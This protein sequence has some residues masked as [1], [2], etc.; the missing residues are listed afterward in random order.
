MKSVYDMTIAA[1]SLAGALAAIG[2]GYTT[3]T[4]NMPFE[5]KETHADDMRL[6]NVQIAQAKVDTA[7]TR[8]LIQSMQRDQWRSLQL[9]LQQRIDAL[10][11][12]INNPQ[13]SPPVRGQLLQARAE[14][15]QQLNEVSVRLNR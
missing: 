2:I 8:M 4:D 7:D 13:T 14:A 10:A 1:G 3:L 9:Q 5:R 15:Q 11:E 12:A 6:V